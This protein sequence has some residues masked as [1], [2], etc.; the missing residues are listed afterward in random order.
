[1]G[2]QPGDLRAA[3][4]LRN[5]NIVP[6]PPF[7]PSPSPSPMLNVSVNLLFRPLASSTMDVGIAAEF[8]AKLVSSETTFDYADFGSLSYFI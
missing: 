8:L 2:F 4:S 6:F 7:P 3:V 1:M 5:R